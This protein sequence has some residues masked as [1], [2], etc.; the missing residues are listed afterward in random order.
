MRS[1]DPPLSCSLR[2]FFMLESTSVGI[3]SSYVIS[4]SNLEVLVNSKSCG[5]FS[6]NLD[7]EDAGAQHYRRQV[8]SM[9]ESYA[10]DYY[11]N[12]KLKMPRCRA[13]IK[14][15]VP[16]NIT[17][18]KCPFL[19]P[20]CLENETAVI[21]FDS[22]LLDVTEYFGLNLPSHEKVQLRRKS[23]CTVLPR[24]GFSKIIKYEDAGPSDTTG[25]N[26][27]PGDEVFILNYGEVTRRISESP[28]WINATLAISLATT[29]AAH[30]TQQCEYRGLFPFR[31]QWFNNSKRSKCICTRKTG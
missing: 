30:T 5:L 25:T 28:E 31:S 12:E 22:G 24:E 18:G 13:F 29:K 16:F 3:F 8:N 10:R 14:P 15:R 17:H 26:Y 6:D 9:S 1:C 7:G 2:F 11:Q 27:S 23:T 20:F 4:F 19:P 21:T